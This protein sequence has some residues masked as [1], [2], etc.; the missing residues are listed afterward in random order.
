MIGRRYVLWSEQIRKNAMRTIAD[1]P[2]QPVLEITI[3]KY[4]KNRTLTQ[5]RYYWGVVVE[6][7]AAHTGYTPEEVHELFKESLLPKQV[8]VFGSREVCCVGSTSRLKTTEFS[9]YVERA[10]A[11]VA[12]ELGIYIPDPHEVTR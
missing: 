5:N 11:Y 12:E 3:R 1:L 9:N 6:M 10:R 4:A 2:L 7:V 8:K